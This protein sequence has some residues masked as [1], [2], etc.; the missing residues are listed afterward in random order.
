MGVVYRAY[1]A[2]LGRDVAI[3]VLA[4][5]AL[6]DEAARRRFRNEARV[7][8]R[9]NH[10]VIQ[11]I[12][13]FDCIEG[14]DLLV[15]ELVPGISLDVRI[16]TVASAEREVVR[17]GTQLA[18]GLAAAHAAGVLHRDG[19]HARPNGSRDRLE[20]SGPVGDCAGFEPVL[21]RGV[22]VQPARARN[23]LAAVTQ[24][25]GQCRGLRL[26]LERPS[27]QVDVERD[28]AVD[29]CRECR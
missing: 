10:P 9:L 8:S 1:D 16:G 15:S 11:T 23:R 6:N 28:T 5:G 21:T 20:E 25:S 26:E 14:H 4:P 2:K 24:E 12:H 3:K 13:D 18:Q 19:R 22:E 29:S 17:I 27:D 7:L